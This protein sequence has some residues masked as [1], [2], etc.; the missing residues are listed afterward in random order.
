MQSTLKKS[1]SPLRLER[2]VQAH[3]MTPLRMYRSLLVQ[4]GVG[5]IEVLVSLIILALGMLGIAGMLLI[6]NQANNSSYMKQQAIQSVYNIFDRIRA[7]SKAAINGNYNI[8]NI[9]TNG[10]PTAVPTPGV[11]C[12]ASACTP[13]Q[14]ATYDRWSWLTTDVAQLPNGCGSITTAPSSSGNTVLTITVQWDD[15]P[16]Q[17]LVGASSP[18]SAANANFVQISIQSQL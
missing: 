4:K 14:L 5:L 18:T 11:Q 8:N 12:T 7:N 13:T 15:T 10:V 17:T 9:G 2:E 6:S 3:T 16:A 1:L